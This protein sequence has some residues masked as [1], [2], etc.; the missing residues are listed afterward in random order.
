LE[1][2]P[3]GVPVGVGV[4]VPEGVRLGVL[5]GVPE[6]VR[7]LSDPLGGNAGTH[8]SAEGALQLSDVHT[9]KSRGLVTA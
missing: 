4:C 8:A 7:E 1:G 6:G 2:V 3:L 5:L 9:V